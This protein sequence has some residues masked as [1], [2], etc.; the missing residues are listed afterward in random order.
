VTEVIGPFRQ[1]QWALAGLTLLGLAVFGV[2][3][4]RAMRQVAQPLT[5]LTSAAQAMERGDFDAPVAT[6]R[7]NDELGRLAQSFVHM[8]SN[9]QHKQAEISRMAF[10]DALTGLPNR[11]RFNRSVHESV[12][13]GSSRGV[14]VLVLN[15]QRFKRINTIMG[16]AVGDELLCAFAQRLREASA[17][18]SASE[19]HT[20]GGLK[21]DHAPLLA[22]LGADTF[23]LLL[24]VPEDQTPEAWSE[25]LAHAF[26]APL[27]LGEQEIDAPV[28]VGLAC[29]PQDAPDADALLARA[30]LALQAAKAR[31][32]RVLRYS[33]ALDVGGE[34]SLSLLSD[35]RQ[36]LRH[37]ELRLYLQPKLALAS[38]Q[39]VAAEAL[40]RWQHPERGLLS[41]AAFIPFAEQT[42]F[43]RELTLWAVD[44]AAAASQA[45]RQQ[46]TPVQ[47]AVNLSV[48]DLLDSGFPG[49]LLELLE[50]HGATPQDFCL[51]ITESAIM[52][53][54]ERAEATLRTLARLGFTLSIDDFGTGYSSLAYLRRLPVNELK[55]DQS[56]VRDMKHNASDRAI[57]AS[58]IGLAHHL[59][60]KVVAEGAE[61]DEEL[62]MLQSMHCDTA[63]GY[64]IARPMP[65]QEMAG[66]IRQ[67][68]ASRRA[69]SAAPNP[70]PPGV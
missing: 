38:Q 9:L 31:A 28:N 47:I 22:R 43:I 40:L 63:Q 26:D 60:L 12:Q 36:A 56:F 66:F 16:F 6:G 49:R 62:A 50:P 44:A 2:A 20:G 14:A 15:I 1:L 67:F 17:Q 30:E 69:Q 19:S 34:D 70:P 24:Q 8:R 13:Q 10:E 7:R 5:A 59:Q 58:T 51:E 53:D 45:L 42:G 48:R 52:D 65:W 35:L 41:P 33:G 18:Q 39:V 11:L 21:A 27:R 4:W 25:R 23:G 64:G 32:L 54:P 37:Q 55:I 57:V 46:G 68:Q 29:W 61:T 3:S